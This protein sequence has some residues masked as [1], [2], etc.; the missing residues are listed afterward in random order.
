MATRDILDIAKELAHVD[1]Q[2]RAKAFRLLS[3]EQAPKVFQHLD[4]VHQEALLRELPEAQADQLVEAMAP[5]DRVRLFDTMSAPDVTQRLVKLRPRER[6]LTAALLDFPAESAGRI[7]TPEFIALQ[8]THTVD[9]AMAEIR[10]RGRI[11][12]M[13]YVLPVTD[14]RGC[15]VGT[16]ALDE[17]VLAQP[18]ARIGDLMATDVHAVRAD[19]DQ[20]AVARLIQTADLLAVPVVDADGHLIGMVTVDDAFDVMDIEESEDLARTGGAEPLRRPYFSASV[21]RVARSRVV[22]L[23]MLA[24]AATLT[25]NVLNAFEATLDQVVSL[26]L[27]IPLLIGTGGNAGAQA[28]TTITRAIAMNEIRF[29]DFVRVILRELRVGVLLG[30]GL[31][32]LSFVPV[33]LFVDRSLA[34]VVSLAL[35]SITTLASLV[36]AMMPILA[37]RVG[38]DPAAVSA[39]FVTTIVDATGLLVYFMIA[40]AV[41]GI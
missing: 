34:L 13:I 26:T 22:W 7:M 39:P 14:E 20:E 29:S 25:V 19:E 32:L 15:P 11:V 35:V 3:P 6:Q 2:V 38:V 4:A 37:R 10:K 31:A 12:E 16:V 5:D 9:E 27:F 36:G 21:F 28:A 30:S 33:W 23:L 17:L 18:E 24:L 8:P 40:R 1:P 41:L